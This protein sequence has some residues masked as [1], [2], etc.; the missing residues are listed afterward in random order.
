MAEEFTPGEAFEL[1]KAYIA[2]GGHLK[3]DEWIAQGMPEPL[4]P[5]DDEPPPEPPPVEPPVEPGEPPTEMLS[6]AD[7]MAENYPDVD[8]ENMSATQLQGMAN[9]YQEYRDTF[10]EPGE[11][12]IE[13]PVEPPPAGTADYQDYLDSGGFLNYNDWLAAGQ[14]SDVESVGGGLGPEVTP[15]EEEEEDFSQQ[16]ADAVAAWQEE[17]RRIGALQAAEAQRLGARGIGKMSRMTQQALLAQGRTAGEIEQLTAGGMEAGAR[18]MSDLIKQINLQ[19]QQQ[20]AGAQ[21]YGI[22]AMIS[23]EELGIRQREMA[24][25]GGQFQQSLAEQIRQFNIEAGQWGQEFDWGKTTWADKIRLQEEATE[26]GLYGDIATGV[27]SFFGGL[28]G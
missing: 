13:P 26:Y 7:W 28:F 15:D 9:L 23:G 25:A 22:G 1:H 6:W 3:L 16:L 10:G 20:V 24:M 2:N 14:P 17:Q 18:S 27:G 5:R 12:P 21:Q 19:T 4:A 8:W 11:P